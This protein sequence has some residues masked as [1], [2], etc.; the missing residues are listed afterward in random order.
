MDDAVSDGG[1]FRSDEACM[2]VCGSWARG[3]VELIRGS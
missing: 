3:G 1:D 2:C